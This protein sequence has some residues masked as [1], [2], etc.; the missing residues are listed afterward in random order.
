MAPAAPPA[1]AGR[2]PRTPDSE[3]TSGMAAAIANGCNPIPPR[4]PQFGAVNGNLDFDVLV[5]GHRI[6]L[7]SSL[8]RIRIDFDRDVFELAL[9]FLLPPAAGLTRILVDLAEGFPYPVSDLRR[10]R[11]DCHIHVGD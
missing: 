2:S 3:E 6:D 5:A 8:R 10:L 11:K 7:G 1:A 4:S 9:D